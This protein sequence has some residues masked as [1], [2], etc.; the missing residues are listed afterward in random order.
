M[1]CSRSVKPCAVTMNG[2]GLSV[3]AVFGV[4]P[5]DFGVG[6]DP[7]KRRVA[8][9]IAQEHAAQAE[10]TGVLVAAGAQAQV[11]AL[12]RIQPPADARARHPLRQ[13]RH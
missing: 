3:C 12:R 5:A 10:G 6:L 2:T 11:L 7:G 9:G 1:P 4:E 13:A 8:P